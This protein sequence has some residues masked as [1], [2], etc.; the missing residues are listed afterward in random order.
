V[1]GCGLPI[2]FRRSV[3]FLP[4]HESL[5]VPRAILLCR[6]VETALGGSRQFDGLA[7]L[8]LSPTWHEDSCLHYP[9][10]AILVCVVFH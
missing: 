9:T 8:F 1:L 10:P 4:Y 2:D 7:G 6:L 5:P 3:S